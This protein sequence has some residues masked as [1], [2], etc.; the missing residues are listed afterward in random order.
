M[1][2][3]TATAAAGAEPAA[4]TRRLEEELRQAGVLE[5]GE[6]DGRVAGAPSSDQF[7]EGRRVVARAWVDRKFKQ[8][9]LADAGSAVAELGLTVEAGHQPGLELHAVENTDTVHNLIVCTLCS[10]YPRALL[11]PP[12][13]WYASEA[14]R[15]KAVR[16]PM[17]VLADFG[18][19]LGGDVAIRVWDSTAQ[20]RYLVIPQ[21]PK[22]T[23]D[24]S[25]D[26]LSELIT[27]DALIGTAL[28]EVPARA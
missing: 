24:W 8:R 26:Q 3:H 2:D 5:V 16:D 23:E 10:C 9:L 19:G 28:V 13:A 22:G 12:P 27:P 15:S 20:T 1:D 6:V 17:G 11:G 7:A 25:E 14:Y 18:V 21:R 4:R